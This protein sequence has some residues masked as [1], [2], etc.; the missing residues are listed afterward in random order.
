MGTWTIE[1]LLGLEPYEFE[2]LLGHLFKKMGY[3]SEV[4]QKSRDM[5]VD[6]LISIENFGLSHTWI[7]QAKRYSEPVG[8][9]EIREYSSLRYRDN[10]DG[11]IIATTSGFTKEAQKEAA[12]HNVKLLDGPLLVKML[13]HYMPENL[14]TNLQ[15]RPISENQ[16]LVNIEGTV[17]KQGEKILGETEVI[18]RG[19][20]VSMACTNKRIFL[21]KNTTGF[22]SKRRDV[23]CSLE[24]KDM[25]GWA[26]EI[27]SFYLV[28][29]SKEITVMSMRARKPEQAAEMLQC[30]QQEYIRGEHLLKFERTKNEFIVLTNKRISKID[31]EGISRE[32]SLKQTLGTEIKGGG[33]LGRSKLILKGNMKENAHIELNCADLLLWKEAIEAAIRVS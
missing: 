20:R 23:L 4:T 29:G 21:I 24:V 30:L 26:Q 18:F 19:E 2:E 9:K 16:E 27:P 12:E 13:S 14:D 6:I 5:G 10:V 3:I 25:L 31:N 22:L 28:M 7:V 8:V 17:L 32:I 1:R 11:V 15:Q 33:V